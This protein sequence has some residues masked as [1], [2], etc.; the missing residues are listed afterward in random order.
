MLDLDRWEAVIRRDPAKRGPASYRDAV[1]RPL[2]PGN[3]ARAV[4]R[5]L[6]AQRILVVTGFC[7]IVDDDVCAET[8]GPPGAVYLAAALAALRREVRIV[9]DRFAAPLVRAGLRI[10]S[11]AES[12]VLEVPQTSDE[13]STRRELALL[14]DALFADAPGAA[15]ALV[16]IEHVGPSHTTDSIAA[17][18]RRSGA[19]EDR[20]VAAVAEFEARVPSSDRDVC[21]NM[22]GVPIGRTTA[23][24]HVLFERPSR[25]D[26]AFVQPYTIGV[27][28]GGNEIGS[29][30]IPWRTW[31]EAIASGPA[32]LTACR[33]PVDAAI[34]AGVSNWGAY[35]LGAAVARAAGQRSFL[36]EWT[37]ARQ[38]LVIEAMVRNAGAVD[39]V[40]K[41]R[42][43]AVDGLALDE[44]LAVFEE[45]RALG[46]SA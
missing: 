11:L 37:A 14:R 18:L 29:G 23:P 43:P 1:E 38:R 19:A 26:E 20:I 36:A 30:S 33:V 4:E 5:L 7:V 13:P 9:V 6:A 46:L 17:E 35:A 24:L 42:E 40:T 10:A 44:Y 41:R 34:P 28:D 22:R 27:L 32:A 25:A 3:L 45:L 2:C 31:R 21:H 39:G 8:D 16:S 15:Q 12:M